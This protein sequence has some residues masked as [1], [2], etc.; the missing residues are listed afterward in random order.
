MLRALVVAA[1]SY[2]L[3]CFVT[4]YYLGHLLDGRDI[5]QSGSGNAGARNVQR[6]H[7]SVPAAT[8]LV[9][10]AAKA[11][12]AVLIAR[13]LLATEWGAWLAVVGVLAGHI[14][15]VQLGFRGGKGVASALGGFFATDLLAACLTSAAGLL[16]YAITGRFVRS[17]LLALAAAPLIMFVLGRAWQSVLLA[18]IAAALVLVAHHPS[19]DRRRAP[20][21][22]HPV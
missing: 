19:I 20:S 3:G 5:R 15:P 12:A 6:L 11:V 14:W 7:G 13:A 1:I 2:A 10:D 8:T 17:G 16:L 18:V 22:E 9:A 4:A 21:P